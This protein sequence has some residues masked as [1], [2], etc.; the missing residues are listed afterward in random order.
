M[1]EVIACAVRVQREK[2]TLVIGP[3]TLLFQLKFLE[4]PIYWV[5]MITK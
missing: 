1:L 4:D 2:V 5:Y 3:W